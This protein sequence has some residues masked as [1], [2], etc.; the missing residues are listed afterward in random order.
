[1]TDALTQFEIDTFYDPVEWVKVALGAV[2]TDQQAAALNGVIN[3]GEQWS[4]IRSGH[5]TGKSA[6]EA[7]LIL[8][9]LHTRPF[10]KV[11]CTAPTGHQLRNILWAEVGKWLHGIID[12]YKGIFT[13]TTDRLKH[14]SKPEDWF[15]VAVASS[16]HN[17][18]AF[19]G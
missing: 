10:S 8:F 5:G 2:P 1:M 14:F 18:E 13:W 12:E 4:S 17:A 19:Q 11:A 16:E 6:T 9:W 7:W 3:G 15:A